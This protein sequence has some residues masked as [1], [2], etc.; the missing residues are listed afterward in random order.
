MFECRSKA[1]NQQSASA[2][3][4]LI[5][6]KAVSPIDVLQAHLDAIS[7]LNPKINAICTLAADQAME[8]E[9]RQRRP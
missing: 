6:S 8:A 3:A 7:R 2:L 4:S 1:L 5:H 9:E